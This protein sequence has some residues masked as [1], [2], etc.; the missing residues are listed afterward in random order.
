MYELV[1]GAFETEDFGENNLF[2]M[3]IFFF[4]ASIFLV[5]IMLNLLIA[6]ISDTFDRV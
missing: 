5:I 6:I 2:L 1:L 3:W 4:G